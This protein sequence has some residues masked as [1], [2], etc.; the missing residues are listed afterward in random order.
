MKILSQIATLALIAEYR[1]SRNMYDTS[2]KDTSDKLVSEL[3]AKTYPVE[4]AKAAIAGLNKQRERED[5]KLG[6]SV[7]S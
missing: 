1:E 4:N 5:A 3:L 7:T 2:T 6:N